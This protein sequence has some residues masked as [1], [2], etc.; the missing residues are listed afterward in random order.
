[1]ANNKAAEKKI[2]AL[3][4]KAA[5]LTEK[6]TNEIYSICEKLDY[7]NSSAFSYNVDRLKHFNT[8][9]QD[10]KIIN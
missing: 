9:L 7:K 10:F 8:P 6:L 5:K 4:N 3:Q 2:L 1:M